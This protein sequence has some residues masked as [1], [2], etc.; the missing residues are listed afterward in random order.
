MKQFEHLEVIPCKQRSADDLHLHQPALHA[1]NGTMTYM[2]DSNIIGRFSYPLSSARLGN[3]TILIID[4]T[5]SLNKIGFVRRFCYPL[6]YARLGNPTI[7]IIDSTV[8]NSSDEEMGQ[9]TVDNANDL[10]GNPTIVII[11]STVSNSSDEEMGQQT[12]D[13]A[14]DQEVKAHLVGATRGH[15]LLKK[16][17][18]ALTVQFCQILKKLVSTK[19]SMGYTMKASSFALTEAKYVAGENIKHVVREN[20]STA[21]LKNGNP[22]STMSPFLKTHFMGAN[23]KFG[24][25]PMKQQLHGGNVHTALPSAASMAGTTEQCLNKSKASQLTIFYGRTVNVFDDISPEK[26]QAIMLLAGNAYVQSNMTQSKLHMQTPTTKH[27]AADQALVS[28]MNVPGL[29]SPVSVSSH[30]ADQAGVNN[31]DVKVSKTASM[32]TTLVNKAEP[33]RVM[34]SIGPV[35]LFHRRTKHL[36]LDFGKSVKRGKGSDLA[37]ARDKVEWSL[38][39]GPEVKL[40]FIIQISGYD[41]V[42]HKD[43]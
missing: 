20:V 7:V 33:T 9:Q 10:E 27:P 26:A 5:L 34:P 12:V 35:D 40:F 14:N 43:I 8:S 30:P 1:N 11:D 28:C 6:S 15:A 17:S 16:K 29:L 38:L 25:G 4:S 42:L 21:A 24:G 32:P 37:E 22:F 3:P 2:L 41:F 39:V 36:W 19:E 23:L 18:D 31:D 13:N